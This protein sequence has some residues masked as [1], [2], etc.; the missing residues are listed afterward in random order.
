[1]GTG[2]REP[3]DR[4]SFRVNQCL[5][6]VYGGSITNALIA[7]RSLHEHV[8]DVADALD[9]T[10]VEGGRQAVSHI[11]GRDTAALDEAGVARAAIESLAEKRKGGLLWE[12]QRQ[13]RAALSAHLELWGTMG[14]AMVPRLKFAST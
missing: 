7:Q 13:Q 12:L 2:V 1:M 6:I 5:G 14:Y 4:P 9:K 10:G 11:V 8:A 3:Q